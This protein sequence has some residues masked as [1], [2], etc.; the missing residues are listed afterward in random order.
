[1]SDAKQRPDATPNQDPQNQTGEDQGAIKGP[2][3]TGHNTQVDDTAR[4]SAG[5]RRRASNGAR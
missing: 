3:R 4:G 5:D 1:M 2:Q